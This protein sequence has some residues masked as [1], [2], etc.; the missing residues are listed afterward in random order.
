[1]SGSTNCRLLFAITY[2]ASNSII[3]VPEI[4]LA[5]VLMFTA[6][7]I[8]A[9]MIVAF[10]L[11]LAM[12][13]QSVKE[14][15]TPLKPVVIMI[16]FPALFTQVINLDGTKFLVCNSISKYPSGYAGVTP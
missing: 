13:A 7:L 3:G 11:A 8:F 16:I 9:I 12:K 5:V 14:A 6:A 15:G 10:E 4:F 2:L 1:M